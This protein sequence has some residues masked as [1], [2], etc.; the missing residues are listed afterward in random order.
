M[1]KILLFSLF[2]FIG[3]NNC[4]A[5]IDSATEYILMD[6]TTGRVLSGKNYNTPM[7]IASITNIM[8][9]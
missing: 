4:Y 6:Q 7:L 9:I 3:I 1:K 2:L 8:T 5:S